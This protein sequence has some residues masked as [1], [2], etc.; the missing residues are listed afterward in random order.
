MRAG[1]LSDPR[2]VHLLRTAFIPCMISALN[3]PELLRDPRD[4]KTL[5]GFVS[6]ATD[7]FNGGEREAFILPDG[8]MQR[9][10]L[11]LRGKGRGRKGDVHYTRAGRRSDSACGVFKDEA[12][13]AL[14]RCKQGLPEDWKQ[15]WAGT[16]PEVRRL[17]ETAPVWP[18]PEKGAA[19]RVFVRNSYL[20]Y[21][22]LS[23]SKLVLPRPA[24][25]EAWLGELDRVGDR[26]KMPAALFARLRAAMMPRGFIAPQPKAASLGG[27]LELIAEAVEG[28]LVHGRVVGDFRIEPKTREETGLRRSAALIFHSRGRLRGRFV[29]NKASKTL[30]ACKLVAEDVDFDFDPQHK[31]AG[32]VDSHHRIGVEWLAPR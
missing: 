22:E 15:I 7:D 32:Y 9:V 24:E 4:A 31:L 11:S 25:L 23:G 5:Q 20:M 28:D 16:H 30:Q 17:A 14:R 18:T 8:K 27:G 29:Y 13:K 2:V 19:L 3:T 21:D 1:L 26:A 10:F 6:K 12:K